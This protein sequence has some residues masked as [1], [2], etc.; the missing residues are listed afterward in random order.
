[1]QVTGQRYRQI[2]NRLSLQVTRGSPSATKHATLPSL[3]ELCALKRHYYSVSWALPAGDRLGQFG[4]AVYHPFP[5]YILFTYKF[6]CLF[7]FVAVVLNA[8]YMNQHIFSNSKVERG[9]TWKE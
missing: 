7:V 5:T 2:G 6:F 4:V 3:L 8:Y 1:M 9:E